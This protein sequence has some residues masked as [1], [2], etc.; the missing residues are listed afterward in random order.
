MLHNIFSIVLTTIILL[1]F[2]IQAAHAF[3]YHEYTVCNT[4]EV[5][6][7]HQHKVNCS[8][9]HKIINQNS[10]DFS[11]EFNLEVRSFFNYTP[12]YFHQNQYT[13]TLQ[14]K[15]SRA[16]PYFISETIF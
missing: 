1:P 5:K 12:I 11:S 10:I 14:L 13:T 2:T 15:S 3:H 7:F 9:Y 6:H 8:D 16:P 4:K